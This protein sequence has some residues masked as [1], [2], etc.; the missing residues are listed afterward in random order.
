LK[1]KQH[2]NLKWTSGEES[3]Q[4]FSRFFNDR[5]TV[6]A[7][8][9][10][11]KEMM[12]KLPNHMSQTIKFACLIGLRLAELVECVKLINDKQAFPTYYKP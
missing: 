8:I 7:M 5:L 11:I 9:L 3:M 4:S 1:L 2:Y 12:G 6:D 10:Q